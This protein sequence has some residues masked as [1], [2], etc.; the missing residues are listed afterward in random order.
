MP[1]TTFGKQPY[2]SRRS[3]PSFTFGASTRDV[4]Q[5]VW[6][7]QEHTALAT[8]GT[9]S[10][11]AVYTLPA[12]V[13]GKQPDGRKPDPPVWI[14]GTAAARMQP[15]RVT[16]NEPGPAAYHV[17]SAIGQKV[18]LSRVRSEPQFTF[19]SKARPPIDP[20]VTSPGPAGYTLKS[21]LGKQDE[22]KM[23][24]GSSFSITSKPKPAEEQAAP[25][26]PGPH[27]AYTLPQSIGKQ[28][29]SKKARAATP[30]FG[31]STRDVR[32]KVYLTYEHEKSFYGTQSTNK[33]YTLPSGLGKQVS[34]KLDTRPRSAFS[35]ASRWAHHEAELKRNTVPGPGSYDY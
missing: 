9:Q 21:T 8:A 14:F 28:P 30:G 12:S 33:W 29:D 18:A 19:A 13:G 34:S 1:R 27:A 16:A 3:E 2:G 26:S 22:S 6:I 31:S 11:G 17:R 24:S 10:P 35:R 4:A 23:L 20:G 25:R 5:K 32:A 15:S 7:S